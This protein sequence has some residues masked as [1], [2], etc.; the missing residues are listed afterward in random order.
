[1]NKI[2]YFIA[3]FVVSFIG[4]FLMNKKKIHPPKKEEI[5][6][7]QGT[8][9]P[10]NVQP[11]SSP[12]DCSFNG[13]VIFPEDMEVMAAA[14]YGGK[15]LD[16]QIDQSGHEAH[17][18]DVT[19]NSDKPLALI[20]AAY[21]PTIWN[22]GWTKNTKIVAVHLNGYH[23]QVAAGLPKEIPVLSSNTTYHGPCP[24]INDSLS[25][26]EALIKTSFKLFGKT[27]AQRFMIKDGVVLIGNPVN[28]GNEIVTSNWK[29]I[30]N[31]QEDKSPLAGPLAIQ[32]AVKQGFLRIPTEEDQKSL[33]KEM[34]K[35]HPGEVA[36]LPHAPYL[37]VKDFTC[38][39]GLYGAHSVSF[40]VPIGVNRP[41]G[42]CG[43]SD[44]YDLN[45][46][47]VCEGSHC[48]T[49]QRIIK[50]WHIEE[51]TK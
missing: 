32:D 14:V 10:K 12:G 35:N 20:L 45:R 4:F 5:V 22:I 2:V 1:M 29:T 46:T 13:T 34:F 37:V 41:Q 8:L 24:K 6:S 26:T 19:V 38:P 43:H 48:V 16:F 31:Y 7:F 51:K 44:I 9:P 17:Q 3:I 47:P 30:M 11:V 25:N 21:E 23:K 42:N 28:E 33:Q 40:I 36:I 15:L 49:N 27:V 50:T 39:E 18:V